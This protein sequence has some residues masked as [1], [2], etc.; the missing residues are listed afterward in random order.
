ML[1]C[2]EICAQFLIITLDLV[3]PWLAKASPGHMAPHKVYSFCN[4]IDPTYVNTENKQ[5]NCHNN[6]ACTHNALNIN[7]QQFVYIHGQKINNIY[8]YKIGI[9]M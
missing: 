9:H 5:Y 3:F 4:Q 1:R 8:K 2:G 6:Y 7:N